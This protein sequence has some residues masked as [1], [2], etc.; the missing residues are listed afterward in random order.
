MQYT[1]WNTKGLNS[2]IKR[3]RVLAHLKKLKADIMF[4]QETHLR[5]QDHVC[6]R[7][8]WIG[9][10]FHSHFQFRS[11]GAAILISKRI[12][13]ISTHVSADP[14]GRFVIVTGHLFN[15]PLILASIYAP[16][17]DDECFFSKYFA[18]IPDL[19]SHSLILGGDFNCVLNPQLDISSKTAQ[20]LTKSAKLIDTFL[21]TVDNG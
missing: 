7:R 20:P 19:N 3:G 1:S 6:L 5:N 10:I 15:V 2:A 18:P 12:P 21:Q 11:R 16:N 4:L 8:G 13:F 17:C 9:Q 14:Q